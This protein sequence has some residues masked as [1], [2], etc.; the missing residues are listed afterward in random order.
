MFAVVQLFFKHI[1]FLS[2]KIDCVLGV[3]KT[4]V[5]FTFFIFTKVSKVV[6]RCRCYRYIGK[7]YYQ[8]EF[9]RFLFIEYIFTDFEKFNYFKL[10]QT[11]RI[12][13]FI[14]SSI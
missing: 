7:E 8:E 14:R 9:S 12:Q 10:N 11:Q 13:L 4:I 2:N 1:Y 3:S 5:S 6:Y